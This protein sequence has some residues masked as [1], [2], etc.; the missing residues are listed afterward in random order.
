LVAASEAIVMPVDMAQPDT[1][2]AKAT[3]ATPRAN[4][5]KGTLMTA[6]FSRYDSGSDLWYYITIVQR[7]L[8]K[9]ITL[10]Y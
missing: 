2:A 5:R 9:Q 4:D 3:A 1:A 8:N 6:S 10:Y 7:R